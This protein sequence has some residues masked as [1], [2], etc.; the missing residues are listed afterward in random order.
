MWLWVLAEAAG[1]DCGGCNMNGATSSHDWL[2][3]LLKFRSERK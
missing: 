2:A 1:K 3:T